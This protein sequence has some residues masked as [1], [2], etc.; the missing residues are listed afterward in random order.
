MLKSLLSVRFKSFF[1]GLVG[2]SKDGKT[3]ALR[4]IGMTILLAVL[5][6]SFLVIIVSVCAPMAM[7]LAPSGL[8]AEYFGL[9]NLIT[10]SIIFIFSIFETKS[11]LFDCKDNELLLS[12]PIRPLDIVISRSMML[13]IVNALEALFIMIPASVMFALFGGSA[14]Y[15]PTSLVVAVLVSLLAT[16]LS[17]AVGYLVAIIAKK[18]RNNSFIPLVASL[19]FLFAY[20]FGYSAFMEMM[21][22]LEETDPE[23]ILQMLA[24]VLAPVAF[25]GRMSLFDPL[26]II[27]FTV[28]TVGITALAWSI[29]SKSYIGIITATY[30]A[31]GKKYKAEKLTRSSVASALAGKEFAALLSNATYMLNSGIGIIFEVLI[32]VFV[33]IS[34]EELMLALGELT[35]LLAIPTEG[36]AALIAVVFM[37]MITS[38]NCMS[39]S[40]LSLEGKRFWIV[41]SAPVSAMDLIYAKLAPHILISAPATLITS[42]IL[43][44]SLS[45]SPIDWIFLI[46]TPQV[47][48]FA[49]AFL[50]LIYNIIWPK[51]DYENDAQVVKQSLPTFL[52]VMTPML[53]IMP[54]IFAGIF[55][56]LSLGAL[57]TE[58]IFLGVFVLL[59]LV[60]YLILTGPIAKRLDKMKP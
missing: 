5:A 39:A 12:M 31:S 58:I 19:V 47:A 29:L 49:A 2:K 42:V 23:V 37:V 27:G 11:E 60:L 8:S 46:L 34:R 55:L 45:V 3:S 44:I 54:L 24:G 6:L 13:I 30:A 22:T 14:W 57:I 1:S 36:L 32:A 20:F 52:C 10:F 15:I 56:F 21:M 48:T 35:M 9:M 50:G 4:V 18:F 40:A 38:T 41:K 17:S 59:F 25:F 7:L 43:G 53:L 51:F 28:I 16:V 33:L 26:Y